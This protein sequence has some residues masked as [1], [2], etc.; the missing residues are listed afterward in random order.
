[1]PCSECNMAKCPFS[2][3]FLFCLREKKSKS[4]FGVIVYFFLD[5]VDFQ[6]TGSW[7]FSSLFFD[8]RPLNVGPPC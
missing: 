3:S 6:S 2:D 1:M 7:D 8:K 5:L 4:K